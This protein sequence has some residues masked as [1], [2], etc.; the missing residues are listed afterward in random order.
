[1]LECNRPKVY[2]MFERTVLC[3][4][5]FFFPFLSLNPRELVSFARV[6]CT[7]WTRIGLSCIPSL[8]YSSIIFPS[9][10]PGH[11]S[12]Y[13]SPMLDAVG[14]LQRSRQ[15]GWHWGC[16]GRHRWADPGYGGLTLCH[17]ST[18]IPLDRSHGGAG[19]RCRGLQRI[20]RAQAVGDDRSELQV[21]RLSRIQA[22][23]SLSK[24]SGRGRAMTKKEKEKKDDDDGY[25]PWWP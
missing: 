8:I 24:S 2:Y 14:R 25:V 18:G 11:S 12:A 15:S 16:C 1:M 23:E 9:L 13:F 20:C 5:T 6:G 17:Q 22:S 19:V 3:A 4:P 7:C 10:P 21:C